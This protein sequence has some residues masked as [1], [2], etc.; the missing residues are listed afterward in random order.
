LIG[1]SIAERYRVDALISAAR[2]SALFRAMDLRE[3]AVALKVF[4]P[5]FLSVDE[6]HRF[7]RDSSTLL[8]VRHPHIVEAL[9]VGSD[10]A[11]GLTYLARTLVVAGS[12][13]DVQAELGV[14]EPSVAVRM[15]LHAAPG[16]G[17]ARRGGVLRG[18]L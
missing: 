1:S 13:Q 14:V 15:A 18:G 5:D 8:M 7:V 3:G 4:Y 11:R 10:P 6:S 16:V 12:V 2:A 17:A 9:G